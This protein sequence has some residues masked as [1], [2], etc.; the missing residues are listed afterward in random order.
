MKVY[1]FGGSKAEPDWYFTECKLSK[2]YYGTDKETKR[3]YCVFYADNV[4]SVGHCFCLSLKQLIVLPFKH[5]LY[6][7][8][9]R[10]KKRQ[11]KNWNRLHAGGDAE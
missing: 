7:S 9:K 4:A 1:V 3:L 11:A 10:A 6:F 8:K 5:R 2:P